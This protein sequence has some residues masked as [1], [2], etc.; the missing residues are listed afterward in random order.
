LASS[1]QRTFILY[2]CFP[3]LNP[4]SL[5]FSA[6]GSAKVIPFSF[7][8]NVFVKKLLINRYLP[9][10][11]GNYELKKSKKGFKNDSGMMNAKNHQIFQ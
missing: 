6:I 4:Y 3:N 11:Q 2:F 5:A 9:L 10:N 8:P 7:H 1:F